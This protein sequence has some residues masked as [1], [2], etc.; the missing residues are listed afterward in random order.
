MSITK[1]LYKDVAPAAENDATV[2][3]ADAS[4][5]STPSLLPSE[6][7][8]VLIS[9][10]ELN[11]W[12]LNGKHSLI[13]GHTLAFWS[14]EMSGIDG[15]FEHAPVIEISFSQQH[16]SLGVTLLFD[17]AGGGY[18]SHINIKWYQGETLKADSDFNPDSS[19]YFCSQKVTSFDKVVLTINNT[20][21]PY[22]YAKLEQI[23]FGIYRYFGM[24]EIRSASVTNQMNLI[25]AELPVSKLS[26]TLDSHDDVDFMFQLKQPVEVRNDNSLIGV[27]YID[28]YRRSAKNIY[29]LECYD[30]FGVLDESTFPGGAY[31]SGIS[32]KELFSTIV[33]G[34]FDVDYETEDVTLIG[35]LQ[36]SSRR[37]AAQQVLFA[38]GA[39]ASTDGRES[40]RVFSL[41]ADLTEIGKNKT[42]TGV[43]VETAAIVTEVKITAHT[44]TQNEN[45]SIEINGTKYQDVQTIY[46]ISNPD[47]TATDKQNVIEVTNAT[48]VSDGIGQTTAQR[49]YDYYQKRNTNKAKIVWNGERLGDYV[50]LPNAWRSTNEGHIEKMSIT[51]SNT[52]AATCEALGG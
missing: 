13:D 42:Y 6:L 30:A 29:S 44:Y 35:V 2:S 36:S 39:C 10:L 24:T 27:Y 17:T 41:D 31:L 51:L 12:G 37:E 28:E 21:L 43:T 38:W 1:I 40:I 18:C 19:S 23:V 22:R 20:N 49:V 9:S 11:Y 26:W 16:S 4:E 7:E 8:A 33:G 3:T 47:V 15:V 14:T 5:F 32:A 25:A 52:V 48:L 50:S 34:F 46:T 45:G